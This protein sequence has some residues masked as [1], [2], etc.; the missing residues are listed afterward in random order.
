MQNRRTFLKQASLM[1]A[2]GVIA[3]QF[4]TACA[5]K[6]ASDK[7]QIGLQ[8]YSLREM[9]K[10]QGIQPVLEAVAKMGY[11][12]VETADYNDGKVYGLAPAEFKKRVEDLGMKC[13]SAHVSP[14]YTREQD[15]EKMAW[16]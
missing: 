9:V 14:S 6:A 8:L 15:A 4:L 2:G 7:K 12:A 16:W 5:G 3:P 1:L 13:T 10:D 11:T